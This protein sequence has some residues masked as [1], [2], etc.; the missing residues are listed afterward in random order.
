MANTTDP[1]ANAVHGTNPQYL[2]EKIT[3]LKIYN[4]VYWKEECFGL[5]AAT[6]IDKAV[7]LKYYGGT[8]GGNLIPT[9]FL[10]LLLKMLQLQPEKEIV[11]EFIQNEDFPYLRI[12]GA[13]YLRL[14]GK[15]E[16][17]YTHLEPLYNDYRT[18]IM[19]NVQG[20]STSHMDE[21]V[22]DLL[23]EE[24]VCDITLPH[25]IKRIKMEEMKLLPPRE[26]LLE[27]ELGEMDEDSDE[28]GDEERKE[29]DNSEESRSPKENVGVELV[30]VQIKENVEVKK[31]VA[32]VTFEEEEGEEEEE[33]KEIQQVAVKDTI[34]EEEV[35]SKNSI[36]QVRDDDNSKR[37]SRS[38]EDR[39]Q[40]ES[41]HRRRSRENDRKNR[42]SRSPSSDRDD[43]RYK[44]KRR[45]R[46]RSRSKGR[47][48]SRDYD[49]RGRREDSRDR[50]RRDRSRS[51]GR[52]S[53]SEDRPSRR[54]KKEDNDL[55]RHE[56]RNS[57]SRKEEKVDEQD[58]RKSKEEDDI[59][60]FS[61][62]NAAQKPNDKQKKNEKLFDKMFGKKKSNDTGGG[63]SKSNTK[64]VGKE[65]VGANGQKFMITAPEGTIEYW[66]QMREALGMKKLK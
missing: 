62:A 30:P 10:C 29:V 61:G 17:I 15:A 27:E 39:R 16:E 42:R 57:Y 46:S 34:P 22:D 3:R 51:R 52:N 4:T 65:V 55:D 45:S 13:F 5:T 35:I 14:T 40:D 28:E 66:N 23:H 54:R 32:A 12:L 25:L 48:D 36:M 6:I 58:R 53:S 7:E 21:F 8:Y 2:V 18:I 31:D 43:R 63:G 56:E 9:K 1:F 37:R 11:Y 44:S 19:R 64:V 50:K 33:R 59:M 47:I 49:R 26:S 24:L 60:E 41:R 38:P 20:F